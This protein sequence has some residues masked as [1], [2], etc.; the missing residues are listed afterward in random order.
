VR[1]PSKDPADYYGHGKRTTEGEW[2]HVFLVP[3]T[4]FVVSKTFDSVVGGA[5]AIVAIG[6][7]VVFLT[8]HSEQS[9]RRK[10][11]HG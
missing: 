5:I 11:E 2:W 1:W 4:V 7:V 9:A 10:S 3:V 8:R 6:I